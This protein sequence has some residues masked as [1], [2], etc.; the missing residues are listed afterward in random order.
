MPTSHA[1]R[2]VNGGMCDRCVLLALR[3]PCGSL[4][5]TP[6]ALLVRDEEHG[7]DRLRRM[8]ARDVTEIHC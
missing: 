7:R 6:V 3:C 4:R 2:R 8:G 1:A 5:V